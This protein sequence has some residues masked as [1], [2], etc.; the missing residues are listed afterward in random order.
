MDTTLRTPQTLIAWLQLLQ[1]SD[2]ALPIGALSHSFGIESLTAEGKLDVPDLARFFAEWLESSGHTEAVFCVRGHRVQDEAEWQWLNATASAMRPARE[3]REASLRLGR[4]FLG[5]A[6]GLEPDE[7]LRFQG[8]VH[9]ATAFGL[10]GAVIGVSAE[11]ALG[12]Y[13]HQTLFGAV[14]ACQRLLPLGQSAAMQLLW[15]MKAQTAHIIQLA[16]EHPDLETLWSLQPMLEIA[17]MRHPLLH[18][19]LFIS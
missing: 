2:S 12:A 6:A 8:E 10:V 11:E 19:R 1:L 15:R 3:S 4:R 18:T 7:R 9:L 14:S 17:S 13:L 5:L 16:C